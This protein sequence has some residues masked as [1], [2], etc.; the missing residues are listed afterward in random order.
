MRSP[1]QVTSDEDLPLHERPSH[2]APALVHEPRQA[3]GPRPF[4][5]LWGA[6]VLVSV[7]MTLPVSAILFLVFLYLVVAGLNLRV[8][9]AVF[10]ALL[11]GWLAFVLRHFAMMRIEIEDTGMVVRSRFMRKDHT[12]WEFL[13]IRHLFG[14]FFTVGNPPTVLTTFIAM[15]VVGRPR[16][17]HLE[18]SRRGALAP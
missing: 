1:N 14:P 3:Q 2:E 5:A 4:T 10:L 17:F 15:L 6:G 18:L 13:R 7:V 9:E 12:P 16:A 11:L 8:A